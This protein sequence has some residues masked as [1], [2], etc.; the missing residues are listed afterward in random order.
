M[1]KVTFLKEPHSGKAL[2]STPSGIWIESLE[3]GGAIQ[4]AIAGVGSAAV[5]ANKQFLEGRKV[6]FLPFTQIE[7]ILA[8]AP[9]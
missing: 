3:L 2:L 5:P 1:V 4:R 9:F 6:L 7:W 8:D